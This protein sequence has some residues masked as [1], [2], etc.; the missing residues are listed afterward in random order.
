MAERGGG[1]VYIGQDL[2]ETGNPDEHCTLD[3]EGLSQVDSGFEF[4]VWPKF[5]HVS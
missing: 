5:R 2:Y 4:E 1:K 3:P